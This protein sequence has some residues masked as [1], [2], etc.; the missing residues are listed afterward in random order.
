MQIGSMGGMS[1]MLQMQQTMK[2]AFTNADADG[3]GKLSKTEF[4]A[5]DAVM[6]A[7]APQGAEGTSG[8]MPTADEMFSKLDA[9]G[10]GSVS[11]DELKPRHGSGGQAMSSDAMSALL[12]AQEDSQTGE[13]SSF[14][15][16]VK[17][18]FTA[19]DKDGDG[20]LSKTEFSAFDTAMK[21]DA[22]QGGTG[23]PSADDM[24]GKLDKDG[25]GSITMD[26]AMRPP[27]PPPQTS[28]SSS[29]TDDET[30]T[31]DM[32]SALIQ[33]MLSSYTGGASD[34]V[35]SMLSATA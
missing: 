31:S 13:A 24:F 35:S 18:A 8:D 9:N 14:A 17:D 33:K 7:D 2:N 5:F 3:D 22:P 4:S 30:S 29:T 26:E 21:A 11:T 12:Q 25:D 32:I 16:K 1:S 6:K 34:V 23:G 10:D 20:K 27:P 19:A 15:S 28:D